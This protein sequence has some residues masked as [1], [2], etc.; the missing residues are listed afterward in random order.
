MRPHSPDGKSEIRMS[1]F[2]MGQWQ[3]SPGFFLSLW[4]SDA[5]HFKISQ[6]PPFVGP[7]CRSTPADLSL[8]K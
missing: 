6:C 2:K 4:F 1:K 7:K 3:G 8:S 5:A